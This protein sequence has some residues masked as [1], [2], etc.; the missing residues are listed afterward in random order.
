[1]DE[2]RNNNQFNLTDR[3]NSSCETDDSNF[4]VDDSPFTT[5]PNKCE[6]YEPMEFTKGFSESSIDDGN[7]SRSYFHLNCRGLSANW[8][9]FRDLLCDLHS[10]SFSFDFIGISEVYRCDRDMRISLPGYH[11]IIT[12]VRDI[13]DDCRGGVGLFTKD[14]I[15]FKVRDDL[16][17]F[18]PHVFESLFIEIKPLSGKPYVVGVIYRPNTAPRADIDIFTTTLLELMDHVNN[19][20]KI[21]VIMGDMNIDLLKFDIH[22]DTNAY[23]DGIFSRGFLPVILR[24][25]RICAT[26]ASLIDHMFTND[27]M[28]HSFSGIIVTDVAD[29]FGT[30]HITNNKKKHNKSMINNIRIFSEKNV[31]SFKL[32]LRNTNFSQILNILCPNQA[33]DRFI[34]LYKEAFELSFP[35]ISYNYSRKSIKRE[36]WMTSGLLV[37]SKYKS[38]LFTKK[39]KKPNDSNINKYKIYLNIFNKL[40]RKAKQNYYKTALELNKS[41]MKQTWKILNQAIGKQ[42]N[43]SKFPQSFKINDETIT[44]QSII[45]NEFNTFFTNIGHNVSHNVPH[46]SKSFDEYL[47]GHHDHSIFLDPVDSEDVI[48]IVKNIKPKTSSGQ[49]EIS[50]KLLICTIS[51]T[52]IPITHIINRSMET[53]IFPDA[54]KCAKV[55]PIYKASDPSIMNNYRPVSLLPSFS[56]ILERVMYNKLMNF[57]NFNNL[58]YRHQYGFRASH[59]TIHPL[60][61]LLNHC[62]EANNQNPSK[63]TL[64]VF[65]DLSKA[66]DTI[67]HKILLHKLNRYGIR[68]IANKWVESYL[69][70]RS[71]YV[72]IQN[73]KSIC[74]NVKCGVPQGSILGPLLFLI[75][76]NDISNSANVNILSFADDTTIYASH[77]DLNVLF[78]QANQN[79]D[80]IFNWFCANK[81][82]LNANKTKYIIIRPPSKPCHTEHHNIL[83]N[84]IPLSRVSINHQEQACKFLGIYIDEFLN[85]KYHIRYINTKIARSLFIMKQVKHFLPY[86]SLRTLYFSLVH[87]Y[88][89]YGITVWGNSNHN[90]ARKTITLQKRAIRTIFNTYYNS[91]TDPLF[92]QSRILKISDLYKHDVLLFMHDFVQHRLPISFDN[93]FKYNRDV[94][95]TYETRQTDLFH[96]SAT[97]N[98]FVDKFPLYEYPNIWNEWFPV[99]EVNVSRN[100]FKN[101]VKSILLNDYSDTVNCKNVFCRDCN[102]RP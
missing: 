13:N 73:N 91:H 102:V 80:K 26:T 4:D 72:Q 55:I 92:K 90:I 12:R 42:N 96:I 17:V 38:K 24:P 69:L 14:N 78:N 31:N 67:S 57:L 25:T 82:S 71:Q 59:S 58:L 41:N 62:A 23:L 11:N 75:Y 70:N 44:D 77:T 15:D 10:D 9:Q 51:E 74:L 29:H 64:A 33:Y 88:L 30:F 18:I 98:K 81:L 68:G 36:T 85:W 97:K 89:S 79:I 39:M 63:Y 52:V 2:I 27:I 95:N 21:G 61:H 34:T 66:F 93:L 20:K 28:Q 5:T 101:K 19:E 43:K 48:S 47:P 37:S 32:A 22:D 16:S 65:C 53:G 54:L 7:H 100:R 50:P 35:S 94:H 46:S 87:P 3:Y 86:E 84:N 8:E 83:I 99:I 76:I 40:K 56:K 49:D 60:I 6:Y 1:M 45:A